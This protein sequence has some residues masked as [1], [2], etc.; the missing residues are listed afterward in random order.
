MSFTSCTT[1]HV[2][3]SG[4]NRARPYLGLNDSHRPSNSDLAQLVKHEGDD[5][6]AVGSIPT[7]GNFLFCSSPSVLAEFCHGLAENNELQ[8]H[9]VVSIS[10]E[11][12]QL[13]IPC[14]PSINTIRN[15]CLTFGLIHHLNL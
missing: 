5:L 11:I 8:K 14:K 1:S 3:L 15:F 2:G 7:G 9:S 4:I 6:E 13:K 12:D 10:Q